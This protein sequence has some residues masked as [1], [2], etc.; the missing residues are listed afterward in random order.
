[1]LGTLEPSRSRAV[2]E[3]Q[4]PVK[5]AEGAAPE[6]KPLDAIEI[7]V[8]AKET[9]RPIANASVRPLIDQV[10]TTR[11]VDA[12][13]RIRIDL[14][15][16]RFDDSFNVDVWAEGYVQQRHYFFENDSRYPRL[17]GQFVVELNP[18]EQTLGGKVT[19]EQGRPVGGVTVKVWGYLGSKKQ[20]DELAYMVEATTDDQ[21]RWRCRCFR[22][23]TFANL[24]LSHPDY[25]ADDGEHARR[26]GSPTPRSQP[27]PGNKSLE[28]LRDFSDVQ[29]LKKG[30]EVSGEVVDEHGKPVPGA[31]VGWFRQSALE[32]FHSDLATMATDDRGR[33]R[34]P[35]VPTGKLVLQVIAR[36]HAPALSVVEARAGGGSS[37]IELGPGKTL[38]GRIVGSQGKPIAGASVIV[39]SWHS[40]RTLG[41]FLKT[42]SEGRFRWDDAPAD[43]VL[44]DADR[45]GYSRVSQ[46]RVAP[47]D[48]EVLITLRRSLS[49]SGKVVDAETNRNVEEA[50]VEVGIANAATGKVDW[51]DDH[52]AFA[53]Q[54]HL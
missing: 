23:M 33:F 37:K 46:Q 32:T 40:Y 36:G 4:A 21:G 47:D 50:Q 51:Q 30:V 2:D 48:G 45:A 11:K 39:D 31:E 3:P 43:H 16:R 49:I 53:S 6:K 18:G 25:L 28:A 27:D 41:V 7:I 5:K 1:M 20:K 34:F 24:Y 13:G 52:R 35:Q 29:V 44:L 9:G 8:R 15:Q 54:G 14:S 42:D 38:T 17:P 10:E 26:H 19:D 12:E 22:D